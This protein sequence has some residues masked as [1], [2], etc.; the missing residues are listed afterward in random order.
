[1]I[2]EKPLNNLSLSE[3]I[4]LVAV[5]LV[6]GLFA[7]GVNDAVNSKQVIHAAGAPVVGNDEAEELGLE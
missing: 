4:W 6:F 7:H 5:L 2:Q 3:I 1:M